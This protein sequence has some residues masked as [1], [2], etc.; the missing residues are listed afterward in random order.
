MVARLNP[1]AVAAEAFAGLLALIALIS[2]LVLDHEDKKRATAEEARIVTAEPSVEYK[3]S[4]GSQQVLITDDFT[5][6][7]AQDAPGQGQSPAGMQRLALEEPP[8]GDA[9]KR[10]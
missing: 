5:L 1:I 4:T 7:G 6:T 10:S 8:H 9:R 2:K 3:A